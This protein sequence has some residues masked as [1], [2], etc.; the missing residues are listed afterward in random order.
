[1]ARPTR[2]VTRT[3]D[4]SA[5]PARPRAYHRM[6]A[7]V[8][9]AERSPPMAARKIPE[10]HNRVSPYL[11]VSGAE[12]ALDFYKQ[13]F[14]AVELFRHKA[15]DGKIGHAEVRIGDTVIM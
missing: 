11:I 3:S 4:G 10:G 12:R 14:G 1:M 8:E 13:A 5:D 15:P 7:G 9:L 6:D 2:S